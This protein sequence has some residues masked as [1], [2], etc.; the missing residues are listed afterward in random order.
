MEVNFFA[1]LRQ[2]VG[3]KTVEISLPQGSNA[4]QLVDEVVRIY[5]ALERELI[6]EHGNLHGHVH[7]VINGRDIR[8]LEGSMDKVISAEDR[9]SLFPAIGG[10]CFQLTPP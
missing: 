10:G 9:V 3:Q 7:V 4:R 6:D 1:G 2:I 8:F 5:P